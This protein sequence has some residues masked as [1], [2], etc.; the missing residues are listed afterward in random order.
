[1]AG[2]GNMPGNITGVFFHHEDNGVLYSV[3]SA[4]AR[5]MPIAK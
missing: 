1:M 5:N 3:L 4:S 2:A